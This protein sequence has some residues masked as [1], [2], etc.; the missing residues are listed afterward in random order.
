MKNI[1]T[2]TIIL[3]INNNLFSQVNYIC[4]FSEEKDKLPIEMCEGFEFN[5]YYS[6]KDN[7]EAHRIVENLMSLSGLPMNFIVSQC[8][9]IKNAFATIREGIQFIIYD[10]KY[11]ES[12]DSNLDKTESITVLAHE[13]G[14]H[15]SGH[16]TK[17][18]LINKYCS[19]KNFNKEK[20]LAQLKLKR[21]QEL[22]ADRFAGFIMYKYNAPLDKVLNTYKQL[23]SSRYNPYSRYPKLEYRL[24]AIKTGYELAKSYD[25][26]IAFVDLE[27][28]KGDKIEFKTN[29]T[30][31]VKRNKLLAKVEQNAILGA[32]NYLDKNLNFYIGTEY[33]TTNTIDTKNE[34]Y[35][36]FLVNYKLSSNDTIN[37]SFQF[38]IQVKNGILKITQAEND[39]IKTVYANTFSEEN[40]N[41]KEIQYIF[42]NLYKEGPQMK[43]QN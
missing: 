29:Y 15:L 40:I 14:H 10:N 27:E 19:T 22:E 20:C 11:L 24:K 18:N 17:I 23:T 13:I 8:S 34:Y 28:I 1:L 33:L 42:A 31:K 5:K 43:S 30:R 39:V 32:S 12:L 16:S 2:A 38:G 6:F 4:A 21:K 41:F 35:K 25:Q 36:P 9:G 3:M 26:K 7:E 37:F